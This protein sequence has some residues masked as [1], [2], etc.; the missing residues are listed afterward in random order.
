M[1]NNFVRESARIYQFPA[2]GRFAAAGHRE[3]T[4]SVVTMMP[5]R[6][7]KIVSGGAWYHEEAIQDSDQG[8]NN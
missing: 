5:P 1:T 3:Q 2:R 6:A 7:G 8:R 4:D